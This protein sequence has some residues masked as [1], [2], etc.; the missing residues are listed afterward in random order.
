MTHDTFLTFPNFSEN[1][2]VSS[3]LLESDKILK[4]KCVNIRTLALTIFKGRDELP[5]D[6]VLLWLFF[7]LI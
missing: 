1:S 5:T 6:Q 3:V 2:V 7:L 4:K